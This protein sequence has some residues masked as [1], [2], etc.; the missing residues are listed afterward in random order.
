ME[1]ELSVPVIWVEDGGAPSAGRLDVLADRLRLDGGSVAARRQR[2]VLFSEIESV[3]FGRTNG[4][5]INGRQAIVLA[6]ADGGSLSFAGFGRPGT[7]LEIAQRLES[8]LG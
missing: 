1:P 3:R 7:L 2:D 8:A 5:R 4:D 6:L